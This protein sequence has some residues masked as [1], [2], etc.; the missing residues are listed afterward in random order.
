M[1]QLLNLVG[2]PSEAVDDAVAVGVRVADGVEATSGVCWSAIAAA[3]CCEF[4]ALSLI[5]QVLWEMTAW[6]PESRGPYT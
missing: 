3:L 1:L 2:T 4:F 5:A 6:C